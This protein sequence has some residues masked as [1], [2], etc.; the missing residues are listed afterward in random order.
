MHASAVL[1]L[2]RADLAIVPGAS[3]S[4]NEPE[5]GSGI[6]TIPYCWRALWRRTCPS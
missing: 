3:G 5:D 1:D 6:D 4:I 2:D